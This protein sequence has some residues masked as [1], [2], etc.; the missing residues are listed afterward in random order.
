M[1]WR[2]VLD[3]AFV[4][5]GLSFIVLGLRARLAP[6]VIRYA[7]YLRLLWCLI[8]TGFVLTGVASLFAQ[9]PLPFGMSAAAAATIGAVII[10]L[11][12]IVAAALMLFVVMSTPLAPFASMYFPP[13][14]R[15]WII[16]HS[17]FAQLVERDGDTTTDWETP[18][19]G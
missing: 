17:L 7:D 3:F 1:P 11:M 8:G 14:V 10:G 16:R 6:R 4:I 12:L 13:K 19:H 5:M 9:P 18:S 15:D 2:A